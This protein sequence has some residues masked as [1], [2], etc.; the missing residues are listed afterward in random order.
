MWK[1]DLFH[2]FLKIIVTQ[3]IVKTSKPDSTS[4]EKAFNTLFEQ[5]RNNFFI[6][7]IVKQ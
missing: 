5:K 4:S 2:I 3:N 1:N 6:A 7:K